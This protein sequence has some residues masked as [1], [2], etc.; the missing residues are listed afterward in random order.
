MTN[1]EWLYSLD[2]SDLKAWFDSEHAGEPDCKPV[3]MLG[4]LDDLVDDDV[5]VDSH[6]KI[7]LSEIA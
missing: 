6:G 4:R 7:A 2:P 3:G 5:S 1:L